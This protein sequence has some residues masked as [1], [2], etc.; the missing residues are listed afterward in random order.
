LAAY[1]GVVSTDS[2][3]W[4]IVFVCVF[5]GHCRSRLQCSQMRESMNVWHRTVQALHIHIL[6]TSLFM[7][8]A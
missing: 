3:M 5:Q 6:P 7:V 8:L 2:H 4:K 1:V